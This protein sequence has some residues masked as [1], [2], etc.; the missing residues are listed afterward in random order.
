[1][2]TVTQNTHT[3][4]LASGCM[5]RPDILRQTLPTWLSCEELDELVIVDWCSKIPLHEDLRE[6]V[7]SRLHFIR[8]EEQ[9]YWCAARCHNV[10]INAAR[11]DNLL[12]I[13]SDIKLDSSFFRE[14]PIDTDGFFWNASWKRSCGDDCHLFGTIYTRRKNFLLVNGYNER[15]ESYGFEDEDLYRRLQEAQVFGREAN[16]KLMFHIPHDTKS[17]LRHIS[18]SFAV[19]TPIMGVGLNLKIAESLPWTAAKDRITEWDIE[20]I[21]DRLWIYKQKSLPCTTTQP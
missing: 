16:R 1:M 3:I 19:D 15:L 6:F 18:P 5:N 20:R 10:E 11:G 12:R 8:V 7:D 17:R 4:S 14:H 21:S 9:T 2:I 13:D